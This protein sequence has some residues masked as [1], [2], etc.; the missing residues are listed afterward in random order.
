MSD[1]SEREAQLLIALSAPDKD[2]DSVPSTI[3]QFITPT[4]VISGD[5][6]PS[7]GLMCTLH[8]HKVCNVCAYAQVHIN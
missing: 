5:P 2:E 8:T 7:S 1:L 6:V 3:L 4:T